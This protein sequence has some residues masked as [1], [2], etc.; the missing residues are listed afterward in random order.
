MEL[1]DELEEIFNVE[2][3]T[4]DYVQDDKIGPPMFKF[5]RKKKEKSSTNAYLI[6]FT[7]YA[8]SP[9][10]DFESYLRIVIGL[11]EVWKLIYE[12]GK[13]KNLILN[14]KGDQVIEINLR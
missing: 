4:P 11:D 14:R 5:F 13:E 7:N 6:L 3:I 9:F 8:R 1:K 10:R 2:D 12:F